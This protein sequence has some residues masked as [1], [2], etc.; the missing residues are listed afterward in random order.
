MFPESESVV[1]V[2]GCRPIRPLLCVV[3]AL[4]FIAGNASAQA[5]KF[6][7]L[8]NDIIEARLKDGSYQNSKRHQ[9]LL[10]VFRKSGCSGER[11]TE[12]KVKGSKLPNVIC[13]VAGETSGVIVV[14]AHFDTVSKSAGVADN[15]SGAILLPSLF[16][17][18]A[19]S[20]RKHSFVFVGF[21]DEEQGLSGSKFYVKS[22][23]DEDRGNIRAMVNLETLGLAPAAAW[24]SR[25]HPTMEEA[26][27]NASRALKMPVH[28]VNVDAVGDTDSTSFMEAG[29]PAITIHSLRQETLPILHTPNDKLSNIQ[30]DDYF[31]A[32]RLISFYI[33]Y[34][35]MAL[36]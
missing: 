4:A 35:D 5:V 11:L 9:K 22:L 10:E 7:T 24:I 13:S 16:E 12:Q 8:P 33:S 27:I 3:G 15:W 18:V 34:L 19:S 36:E 25:A 32:Y 26:F 6:S 28:A 1:F 30:W 2:V 31:A 21:T 23:A 17:N 29:I 20:P 14:G